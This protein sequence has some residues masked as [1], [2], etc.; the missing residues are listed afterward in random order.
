M[1]SAD[2]IAA[3]AR[4]VAAAASSPSRVVLFGSY[5]RGTA[6]DGSDLDLLVIQRE[7]PNRAAEYLRLRQAV[8]SVG[9]GVDVVVYSEQEATRRA[10]VPGTLLYWAIKEGRVLHDA[11]A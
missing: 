7:V 2:A 10:Q 5:A 8:G 9:I 11:L 1:L 3:A 4:R 6:D